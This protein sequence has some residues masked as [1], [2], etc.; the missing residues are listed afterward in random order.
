V[1]RVFFSVRDDKNRSSLASVDV[2]LKDHRFQLVSEV[3]GPHLSPGVRGAFDAD[4][5]NVSCVIQEGDRLLGYYLGWTV[6]AHV[7]FTNFIG[8]AEAAA[9][10]ADFERRYRAPIVGR[11]EINPFGVAYPWVVRFGDSWRMYFGS[12]T[13]GREGLDCRMV[14]KGAR[15]HDG[16]IWQQEPNVVIPLLGE[17]DP[18]EFAVSRVVVLR[19]D[20]AWSMWYARRNP[21]YR[22]G[23]ACS[24]DGE[25]WVRRDDLFTFVGAAERWEATMQTYPCVF[26]HQGR[27]YMLY[28][29]D[30]YGRTGF[31]IAVLEN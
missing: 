7:P 2:A 13:W 21:D 19:D 28:N 1:I 20:S 5:V 11:S 3:S 26:D 30:G 12:M 4:G 31:G 8:L 24:E 15:S 23:Y 29:G 25:S 18:S 9:S 14:I 6:G 16:R 27:R 22:I 17:K 10:G